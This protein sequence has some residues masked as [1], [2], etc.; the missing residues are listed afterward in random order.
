MSVTPDKRARIARERI[1]RQRELIVRME[2]RGE[3][4]SEAKSL[5][6][7]MCYTLRLSMRHQRRAKLN[8]PAGGPLGHDRI[9]TRRRE[10]TAS[11]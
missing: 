8:H 10:G 9:A 5:L 6:S 2:A 1:A 7:A 4:A 3:D 11:R